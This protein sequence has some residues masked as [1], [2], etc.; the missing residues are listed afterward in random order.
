MA[1]DVEEHI[2]PFVLEAYEAC[3]RRV[4]GVYEACKSVRGV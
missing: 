3:K 2:C 4:R 1:R